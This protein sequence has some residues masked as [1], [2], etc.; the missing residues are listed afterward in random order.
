MPLRRKNEKTII[1]VN[2][3]MDLV[4]PRLFFENKIHLFDKSRVRKIVN[5]VLQKEKYLPSLE[6]VHS[7]MF[8]TI[9][10][11]NKMFSNKFSVTVI[12]C[13]F[14]KFF[15]LWIC[16]ESVCLFSPNME[17]NGNVKTCKTIFNKWSVSDSCFSFFPSSILLIFLCHTSS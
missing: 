10:N 17:K 7:N 2:S 12:S 4:M 5:E 1:L 3:K 15:G 9:F 6:Q 11:V 14:R 8:L 16:I 13:I